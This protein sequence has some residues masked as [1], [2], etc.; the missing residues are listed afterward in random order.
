MRLKRL[1]YDKLF[2]KGHEYGAI[3]RVGTDGTVM[4]TVTVRYLK[5][6]PTFRKLNREDLANVENAIVEDQ[7]VDLTYMDRFSFGIDWEV[8]EVQFREEL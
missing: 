1:T 7:Y 4:A 6:L 3:V 2:T 5:E 8:V